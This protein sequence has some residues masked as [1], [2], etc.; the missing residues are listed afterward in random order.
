MPDADALSITQ[1]RKHLRTNTIG[2]GI[3]ILDTVD[4]TNTYLKRLAA[5]GCP[6]G[7]VVIADAQTVGRGRFGKSFASPR[8]GVYM[9]LLLKPGVLINEI[10]FITICL[11]VAVSRAIDGVCGLDT[12]VKWVNDVYVGDK[13]ISGILAE[14][15]VSGGVGFVVAG[16]GVNTGAIPDGFGDIAT[17]V[18]NET[19]KKGF[20]NALIAA[21]MN[22]TEEVYKNLTDARHRRAV[23]DEY[24]SK[25][26]ILT[27]RVRITTESESFDATVT[28]VA[29]TGEL[30]VRDEDGREQRVLSGEIEWRG[31]E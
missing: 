2:S 30:L 23:L 29:E 24:V 18:Y 4:S 28:D 1:I 6:D 7:Y 26:F 9:S 8:G 14:S 11:A 13:K 20:R 15:V 12:S 17:S 3:E 27:K 16:I 22:E 5:A 10:P 25:L 19:G 21:L 31:L